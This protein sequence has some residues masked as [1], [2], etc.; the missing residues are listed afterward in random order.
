MPAWPIVKAILALLPPRFKFSLF[1]LAAKASTACG[2][3]LCYNI[4]RLPFNTIMKF[5]RDAHVNEAHALR[6]VETIPGVHTPSLIDYASGPDGAFIL[7]TRINGDCV[8]DVWDALTPF[9]ESR[10]V[11]EISTQLSCLKA[12]AE[13]RRQCDGA[14]DTGV[15]CAASG[16][17][18]ADPRV[19]WLQED[20]PQILPSCRQFFEQ[21]WLGL[22]FP[23][24]ANTLRPLIRPL[25][26]HLDGAPVVFCHGDILPKNLML[27]GGIEK[28]RLGTA[29]LVLIDW[30]YAGWMPA[31]WEALKATWLVF[32]RDEEDDWY[33]MMKEVFKEQAAVLEADWLWRS[34]SGIPIV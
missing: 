3:Q 17:P 5:T 13:S 11:A 8:A 4:Y 30:E 1:I 33:P 14:T 18:I 23:R 7:M 10:I 31:P 29:P 20:S 15:I 24:N 26:E 2:W 28:W 19:P 21:V 34:K 25:I 12:H 16:A 22:D 9:D 32:D 27:P 6:I